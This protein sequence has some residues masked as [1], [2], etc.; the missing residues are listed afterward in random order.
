M[1]AV[2]KLLAPV[3]VPP[4]KQY[5]I[6]PLHV[7]RM[8]LGLLDEGSGFGMQAAQLHVDWQLELML[9]AAEQAGA[10]GGLQHWQRAGAP[11]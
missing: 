2:M 4:A 3:A 10:S 8:Y 5:H 1:Q 7:Q 6:W 9:P 11:V